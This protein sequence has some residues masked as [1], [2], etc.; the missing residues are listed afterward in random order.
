MHGWKMGLGCGASSCATG[1][2]HTRTGGGRAARDGL[3]RG[4]GHCPLTWWEQEQSM[5]PPSLSPDWAPVP[6]SPTTGLWARQWRG[7]PRPPLW[8]PPGKWS[9]CPVG[10]MSRG[11]KAFSLYKPLDLFYNPDLRKPN[12]GHFLVLFQC[13]SQWLVRC[14][15]LNMHL[16]CTSNAY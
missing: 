10:I 4:Y 2:T 8:F 9:T 12:T 13:W 1:R 5:C 15:A 7:R 14:L 11:S 16:V 6:V 3:C